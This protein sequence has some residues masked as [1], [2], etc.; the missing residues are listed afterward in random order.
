MVTKRN[1]TRWTFSLE[2]K[3]GKVLAVTGVVLCGLVLFSFF[4][5]EMGFTKYMAMSKRSRVLQQDI[6]LLEQSNAG[7]RKEIF[8]LQHDSARVEELARE[9]LGLV[10]HGETVYQLVQPQHLS[11]AKP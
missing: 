8:R 3:T 5:D 7:L 11:S 2:S 10:R 1:R 9:Q 4:F 6:S